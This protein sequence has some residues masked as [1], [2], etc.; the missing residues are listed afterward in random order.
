MQ[1]MMFALVLDKETLLQCQCCINCV[2]M[3]SSVVKSIL[4]QQWIMEEKKSEQRRKTIKITCFEMEI[5]G[6]KEFKSFECRQNTQHSMRLKPFSCDEQS[7]WQN[8]ELVRS[9]ACWLAGSVWVVP[10]A[11]KCKHTNGMHFRFE[12]AREIL[13]C[14]AI[15]KIGMLWIHKKKT[16]NLVVCEWQHTIFGR[17]FRSPGVWIKYSCCKYANKFQWNFPCIRMRTFSVRSDGRVCAG[18]FRPND[19][20]VCNN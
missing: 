1:G 8:P 4:A 11:L 7:K 19:N 2:V 16:L 17:I 12:M 3:A 15:Y 20:L 14:N 6:I 5:R 10:Y 18:V 13:W 9:L